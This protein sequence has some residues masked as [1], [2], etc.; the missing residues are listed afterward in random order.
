MLSKQTIM[1]EWRK[2]VERRD[3]MTRAYIDVDVDRTPDDALPETPCGGA[4]RL[5]ASLTF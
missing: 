5:P 3:A 2:F 1:R 4:V